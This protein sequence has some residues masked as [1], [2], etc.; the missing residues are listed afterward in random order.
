M[1]EL[2]ERAVANGGWPQVEVKCKKVV[3]KRIDGR[4]LGVPMKHH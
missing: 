4:T 1:I 2:L 3:D